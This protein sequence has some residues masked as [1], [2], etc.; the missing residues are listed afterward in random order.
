MGSLAQYAVHPLK[1]VETTPGKFS[2]LLDA[3]TTP[4]DQLVEQLGHE[5]NGYFWA[6]VAR[7]L[8]RTKA[9]QLDGR[10]GYDPEAGMFCA[11][12]S[13]RA[14]LADLG[15]LMAAVA[16]DPERM[17]TLVELARAKGFEFDD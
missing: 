13:D 4:V 16:T 9:P 8:V 5:P 1:L 12:G 11:Y 7:L 15:K 14:A 2:L 10:F 6:G 17:R 3:G